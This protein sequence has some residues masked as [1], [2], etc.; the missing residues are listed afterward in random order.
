M[1]NYQ[2]NM[3]MDMGQELGWDGT[4]QKE[5]EFII[6]P[7]GDYNFVVGGVER[8]R[9][10]GSA[11]M[12]PAPQ[13]NVQII[14][15]KGTMEELTIIHRLILNTKMEGKISEFFRGIG[16]KKK[17]Q[18]LQMDWNAVPGKTGRCKIAH[19]TYEGNTFNDIKEFYPNDNPQVAPQPQQ[20]GQQYQQSTQYQQP[21]QQYQ[22]PQQQQFT[23]TQSA[24]QQYQPGTF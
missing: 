10:N 4:I 3:G 14:I 2:N 12:N 13:A 22:Q 20:Y 9:F 24:N 7:P 21:Q 8:A 1:E 19:R 11:K 17:D 15:N 16:L 18:L 5:N 23:Q 6:L